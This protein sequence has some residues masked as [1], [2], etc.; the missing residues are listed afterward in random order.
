MKWVAAALTVLSS[1]SAWL[2][3]PTEGEQILEAA[4]SAC[5]VQESYLYF[6]GEQQDQQGLVLAVDYSSDGSSFDKKC[7]DRELAR[8]GVRTP[9]VKNPA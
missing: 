1:V 6:V 4:A 8:Q 5:G 9:I 2:I 3:W 7:V